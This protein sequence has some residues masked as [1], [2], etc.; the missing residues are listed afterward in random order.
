V[1]L[2]PPPE[3][4]DLATILATPVESPRDL[5]IQTLEEDLQREQDGRKEERFVYGLIGLLLV[6]FIAFPGMP[7]FGIATCFILE[8]VLVVI[9][10]RMCGV[11]NVHLVTDWAM[12]VVTDRFKKE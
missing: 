8:L 9:F 1:S 4:E 11:E 6:N 5:Q 12:R 3:R 2:P 7:W 10:G